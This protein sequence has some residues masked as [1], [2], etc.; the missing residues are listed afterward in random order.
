[1][2][3][4]NRGNKRLRTT[5]RWYNV[6]RTSGASRGLRRSWGLGALWECKSNGEKRKKGNKGVHIE[7]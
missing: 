4:E 1:M 7:L 6:G 5:A 3:A 2:E